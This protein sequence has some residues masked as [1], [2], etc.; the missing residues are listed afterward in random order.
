MT[1]AS[2]KRHRHP[3]AIIF[4]AVWLYLRFS[5]SLRAVEE[6]LLARGV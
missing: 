4:H 6:M 1:P 2:Y 3:P 5:L